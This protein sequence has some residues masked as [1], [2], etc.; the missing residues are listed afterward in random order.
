[1]VFGWP[2]ARAV[3]SA[4]TSSGAGVTVRVRLLMI[5][6]YLLSLPSGSTRVQKRSGNLLGDAG[7][8]NG[9]ENRRDVVTSP[10]ASDGCGKFRVW[11]TIEPAG[12][13]CRN[14]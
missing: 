8:G 14:H 7:I 1:M 10:E 4:M 3:S 11:I 2:A 13:D 9:A 6:V 5:T 12:I